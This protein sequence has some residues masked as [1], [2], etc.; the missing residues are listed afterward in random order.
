MPRIWFWWLV[1]CCCQG[2]PTPPSLI[3]GSGTDRNS[4]FSESLQGIP[5]IFSS[6]QH[7]SLVFYSCLLS[8]VFQKLSSRPDFASIQQLLQQEKRINFSLMQICIQILALLF[9]DCVTWENCSTCLILCF[10]IYKIKTNRTCNAGFLMEKEIATHSSIIAW[11][12]NEQR[13]LAGYSPWGC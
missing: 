1:P 2:F 8:K 12:L 10:P 3:S 4:V 11:K 13:S 7:S 6:A 9:T 5:A